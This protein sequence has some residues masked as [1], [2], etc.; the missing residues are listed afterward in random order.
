LIVIDILKKK[1][2]FGLS[3]DI[4][5]LINLGIADWIRAYM[6]VLRIFGNESAHEKST[7]GRIPVNITAS[8]L[9]LC[10]FCLQRLLEFYLDFKKTEA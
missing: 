6:H 1:E 4:N 3:K 8:D 10:L 9:A 5:K 7:S 2:I